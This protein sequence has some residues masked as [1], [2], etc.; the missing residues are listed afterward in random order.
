MIAHFLETS[1]TFQNGEVFIA[2]GILF[3]AL[4]V[5]LVATYVSAINK[6]D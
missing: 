2:Y 4:T 1:V 6:Q 5:L 3:G